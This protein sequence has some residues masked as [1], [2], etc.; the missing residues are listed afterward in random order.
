MLGCG[1]IAPNVLKAV[2]YDP[3]QYQGFAFGLGIDRIAMRK[4]EIN[5][6]Q[7]LYQGDIRFLR[8]FR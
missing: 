8:Q 6:I 1:M 2:K 7:L 3:E 5:D 4:Y